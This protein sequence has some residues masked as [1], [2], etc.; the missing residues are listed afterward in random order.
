MASEEESFVILS[1]SPSLIEPYSLLQIP[2]SIVSLESINEDQNVFLDN[3]FQPAL[4]N[5][6]EM[7]CIYKRKS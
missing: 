4:I 6:V 3:H 2:N 7:E 5:T 1:E